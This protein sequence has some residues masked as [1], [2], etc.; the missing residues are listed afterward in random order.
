M[1]TDISLLFFDPHTLNGSLD[2]ALV[3]IVD[4]EAAR[5]RHSDNG[6][7]IPSGTLHAQ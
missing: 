2:S 3:A 6:L 5:A 1:T 4:T 7:F